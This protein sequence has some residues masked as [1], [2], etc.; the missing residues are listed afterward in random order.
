MNSQSLPRLLARN[1]STSFDPRACWCLDAEYAPVIA[2][3]EAP[4]ASA[5]PFVDEMEDLRSPLADCDFA[6]T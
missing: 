1:Q 6:E 5:E 4:A 3:K 2:M